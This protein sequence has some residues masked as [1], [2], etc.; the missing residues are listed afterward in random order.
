MLIAALLAGGCGRDLSSYRRPHRLV[1]GYTLILPGV[2]GQSYL[3]RH[4]VEGLAEGGVPSGIEIYD[5]TFGGWFTVPVNLRYE[6]RNRRE[7]N[8][9]AQKIMAYQDA[10]PGR[11]VHLIGHSGGGGVAVY[12]LEALPANRQITATILLAP[13]LAPD[14]DLSRALE[15]TRDGI[16]HFYS[17]HDV[18]WLVAGTTVMGTVDGSH[19]RAAGAVGFSTPWGLSAEN[20]QLYRDKL[21]QQ[22]YTPKM[23][24]SGHRGGHTGWANPHFVADWLAPLILSHF[25]EQTQYAVDDPTANALTTPG[26]GAPLP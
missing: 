3:N 12:V 9:I 10:Y 23:A 2:E 25:D 1:Q 17:P 11:P 8:K 15:H 13:A 18:G 4:I 26:A 21:R 16:W 24:H 5:W 14:Y 7:A 20:R 19:T 6:T 22:V